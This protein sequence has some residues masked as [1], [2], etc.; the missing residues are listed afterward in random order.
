MLFYAEMKENPCI[1][2]I[3]GAT[4]DLAN[5]KLLPAL[6]YLEQEKRL[7]ESF[8]ILGIGRKEKGNEQ[9]RLSSAESI[10]NSSKRKINDEALK[11]LVSR[12]SYKQLDMPNPSD[13]KA[14]RESIEGICGE[15]CANCERIFYLAV[16]SSS[17]SIIVNN[18]K[19]VNLAENENGKENKNTAYNRVIFEKP[20]G[21]DLKSAQKLNSAITKVFDER[22]IYRI[23]HYMAKELVQNLIV[24]RFANNIYE[25]LWSKEHIDHVQITVAETLGVEGRGEYYDKTGA[26]RDVMQNHMMQLL[27]LAAMESPKGLSADALRKEKVKVLKSVLKLAKNNVKKNAVIGQYTSGLIHGGKAVS[28]TEEDEVI[29]DSKTETFTALKLEI[30]SKMWEGVPFYLRTGKRLKE[31]ATEIVIVY[32]DAKSMLFKDLNPHKNMLIIRVQPYEGIT[33]EFN[34]KVPGNR[35]IIDNVNMDFCHECKFGLNSPEDYERLLNDVMAGDHTLFT[36]WDEVENSWR[37]FDALTSAFSNVGPFK[38][39]AGSWGPI[40]AFKLI[41]KD[42]RKWVE[43]KKPSYADLLGK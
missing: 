19:A 39:S 21:H 24:L 10:K 42:G 4:G 6:Y 40:E 5:R 35:I 18:L 25:P 12:I 14:L 36:S 34:A 33:L 1:L 3:F 38:Y 22:Q 29:K 20:F 8:K 15:K 26:I 32:K 27:T 17:F 30:D 11:K 23:D 43:P 28:Y 2:A 31:R 16:P 13:Y 37:I 41:E 9:F 7:K